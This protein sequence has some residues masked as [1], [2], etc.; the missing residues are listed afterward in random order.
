VSEIGKSENRK[1]ETE[2]ILEVL[3]RKS[4]KGSVCSSVLKLFLKAVSYF[5]M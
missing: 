1:K 5:K 3:S 4:R 2:T